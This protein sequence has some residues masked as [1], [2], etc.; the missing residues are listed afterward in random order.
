MGD[1]DRYIEEGKDSGQSWFTGLS[2][3]EQNAWLDSSG[4]FIRKKTTY[5][6]S[7]NMK[8]PADADYK[9]FTWY[10]NHFSGIFNQFPYQQGTIFSMLRK[11]YSPQDAL[12]KARELQQASQNANQPTTPTV[13]TVPT[14][15][16]PT[17][18]NL[19]FG[20]LFGGMFDNMSDFMSQVT[21]TTP[22]MDDVL[23]IID[24]LTTEGQDSTEVD[25][26]IPDMPT[27]PAP[28]LT[29]LD[30]L[31][32]KTKSKRL[33]GLRHLYPHALHQIIE[34]YEDIYSKQFALLTARKGQPN[35][36][37]QRQTR[38]S[39]ARRLRTSRQLPQRRQTQWL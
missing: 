32:Y 10:K 5:E 26:A 23:G 17:P 14:P 31:A 3:K 39:T 1:I 4:G 22:K 30:L 16:T 7:S 20:D 8:Q 11:G 13:P 21:Q 27:Q 35:E 34:I 36:S 25:T 28:E 9:T 24:Q 37:I 6:I 12:K 15:T 19:D 29:E 38:N 18:I 2:P 33:W